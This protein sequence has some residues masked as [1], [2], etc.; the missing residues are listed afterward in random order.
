MLV[1]T[2][3]VNKRKIAVILAFLAVV[4]AAVLMLVH[5]SRQDA[6]APETLPA[7]EGNEE[8]VRF[9]TDKGWDV[10]PAPAETTQ[11]RIPK[12]PDPVYERYNA[13]QKSQGFDLNT[14]AGKNVMRYVYEIRN[15]PGTSS[16]VYATLLVSDGKIIGGDITDRS[17]RGQ[18]Q[19]F[20]MPD[21][22]NLPTAEMPAAESTVPSVPQESTAETVPHL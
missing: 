21:T 18:V 16:Q 4:V 19:G 22:E 6:A 8:R 5:G 1:M 9:L 12:Q 11:V 7:A 2:A 15:F 17:D 10:V 20:T 14:Y 13:L 3:K